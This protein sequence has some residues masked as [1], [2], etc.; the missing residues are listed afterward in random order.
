[1]KNLV[2]DSDVLC[3]NQGTEVQQKFLIAMFF[4]KKKSLAITDS[5]V[6]FWSII[7]SKTKS[8]DNN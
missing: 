2:Y 5:Q 3:Q 6:F 8:L 4:N 7:A 1:M